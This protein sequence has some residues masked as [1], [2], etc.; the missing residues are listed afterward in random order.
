[1]LE[2]E[3]YV[4]AAQ[5][6]AFVDAVLDAATP[7]SVADVFSERAAASGAHASLQ[8][9]EEE[10]D[11]AGTAEELTA[12]IDGAGDRDLEPPVV[13]A[14]G[15]RRADGS[16]GPG[17]GGVDERPLAT[18]PFTDALDPIVLEFPNGARVSLN[19]TTIVERQVFF[20]ARSPGGLV[21]SPTPTCRRRSAR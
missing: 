10:L 5:E 16:P 8:C 17:G 11:F 15:R 3:W 6:F 18:D 19:T 4:T 13:E 21:P 14:G 7:E 2:D 12:V 20:E 9:P 1:M